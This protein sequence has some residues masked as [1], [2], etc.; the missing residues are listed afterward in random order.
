MHLLHIGD[1]TV[2]L[3]ALSYNNEFYDLEQMMVL[4][5]LEKCEE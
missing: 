3:C 2:Y 1:K 4:L 5:N